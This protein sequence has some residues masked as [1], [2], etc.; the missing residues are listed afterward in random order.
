MLNKLEREFCHYD[1]V[2]FKENDIH[3]IAKA[4]ENND[5]L[6]RLMFEGFDENPATQMKGKGVAQIIGAL[7]F[8]QRLT[9]LSFYQC[10]IGT[11]GAMAVAELMKEKTPLKELDIVDSTI[12][13]ETI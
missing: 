8:N 2:V 9:S 13:M 1:R 3:E 6:N 12:G 10:A 7:K 5:T 4:L 11:E